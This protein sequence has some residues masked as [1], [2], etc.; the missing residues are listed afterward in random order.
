MVEIGK[1]CQVA[2]T[3]F[4]HFDPLHRDPRKGRNTQEFAKIYKDVFTEQKR[5]ES[6]PNRREPYTVKLQEHLHNIVQKLKWTSKPAA[7]SN[8]FGAGLMGGFRKRE[9]AQPDNNTDIRKPF[10]NPRK[11]PY[12]FVLDDVQFLK[13]G[14]IRISRATAM[15]YPHLVEHVLVTFKY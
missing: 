6:V 4:Q 1:Y 11:E 5:Y 7:M 15:T 12:A 9:W 13:A 10:L 14:E 3:L 2:A 8:W